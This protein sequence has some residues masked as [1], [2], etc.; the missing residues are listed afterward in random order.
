MAVA[1]ETIG[2]VKAR[3]DLFVIRGAHRTRLVKGMR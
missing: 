1:A 3:I 2:H